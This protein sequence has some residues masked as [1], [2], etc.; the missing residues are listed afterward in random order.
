MAIYG[1]III[2]VTT[3]DTYQFA[4]VAVDEVGN[5]STPKV[6]SIIVSGV[7][8]SPTNLSLSYDSVNKQITLT[9]V[10]P[11]NSDLDEL[12]V[13]GSGGTSDY[14][15][16]SSP[17]DTIASGVQQYQ[18]ATN[19]ADGTYAYIVRAKSTNG[20]IE[21]NGS[22]VGQI[23][24]QTPAAPYGV[25]SVPIAGGGAEIVWNKPVLTD[26]AFFK[27]ITPTRFRI[28]SDGGSL[29][30]CT[31]LESSVE[32]ETAISQSCTLA[33]LTASGSELW[34]FAVSGTYGSAEG[35]KSNMASAILDAVVPSAVA[36]AT[37]EVVA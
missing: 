1:S 31:T 3:N 26:N 14:P 35:I 16:L 27:Y 19:L 12:L 21:R 4:I 11:T 10:D 2:G 30:S 36:T 29:A 28:Y 13:Y 15:D 23:I 8:N 34:K 25:I 9:W 24:P 6:G 33:S 20:K 17:I 5:E 32:A 37:L 18:T 7:P 22:V